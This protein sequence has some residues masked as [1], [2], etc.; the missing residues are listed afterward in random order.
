[1]FWFKIVHINNLSN[2]ELKNNYVF[3]YQ[4][5]SISTNGKDYLR[6]S[7]LYR[8][9]PD[10]IKEYL[11]EPEELMKG[12]IKG[13]IIQEYFDEKYKSLPLYQIEYYW[14]KVN[15]SNTKCYGFYKLVH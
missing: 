3:D 10:K 14:K 5:N 12:I 8:V 1:M 4:I 7:D 13:K 2:E 15:E 9:I 6:E 11:D